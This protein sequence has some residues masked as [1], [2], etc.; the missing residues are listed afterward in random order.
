MSPYFYKLKHIPTGR[1]YVGCQ[2][3]KNSHPTN[4]MDTYLTSSRYVRNLIEVDGITAFQVVY[5]IARPD[6]REYERK[7]LT[8]VYEYLGKERFM[9]IMINRTLSPGILL[10]DIAIQKMK[11]TRAVRMLNGSIKPNV[12]PSWKGKK[13]STTMR[14]RLSASK[15][16][17]TVSSQTREKIRDSLIGKSQSDETKK[18]RAESLSKSKNAYGKKHWLFISPDKKYYYTIGKRNDRLYDLGLSAGPGFINYV[19]TGNSPSNGKNIGW[20]FF[21]GEDNILKLLS[22]INEMNIIKYE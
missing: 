22:T 9:S 13:R 15:M 5:I 3:G 19:N 10:D 18:R 2:Y 7:Y 4:L 21:E 14:E 12:P 8:R 17:H 1:Y 6:A 20:L 11:E 16:G